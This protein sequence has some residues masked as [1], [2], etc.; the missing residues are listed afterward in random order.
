MLLSPKI[1]TA[2]MSPSSGAVI[3]SALRLWRIEL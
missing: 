1:A 3:T 2:A